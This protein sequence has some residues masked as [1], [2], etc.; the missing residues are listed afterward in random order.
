MSTAHL[1]RYLGWILFFIMW[2][3][4]SVAGIDRTG[5]AAPD[6]WICRA[7]S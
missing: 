1:L 3:P 2:W 5:A 4:A 7:H 6:Q